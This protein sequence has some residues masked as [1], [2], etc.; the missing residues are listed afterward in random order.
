[1]ETSLFCIECDS[2][3][4]ETKTIDFE[5]H[6]PDG[7]EFTYKKV[8]H[9]CSNCDEEGVFL[10]SISKENHERYLVALKA[11][12]AKALNQVLEDFSAWGFSLAHIERS[13]TL[14]QRTISRWKAA[15]DTE[16]EISAAGIALLRAIHTYPWML[17]VADK[18]FRKVDADKELLKQAWDIFESRKPLE[19]VPA[20]NTESD[21]TPTS[22]IESESS[23]ESNGNIVHY[24]FREQA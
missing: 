16:K 15:G 24:D 2:E 22:S 6:L 14:P 10:R 23:T 20:L 9:T 4:I 21:G 5:V 19:D 13:L 17:N 8:V 12:N 3:N 7:V 18:G 1:M 11:T